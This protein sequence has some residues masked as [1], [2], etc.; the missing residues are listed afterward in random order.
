MNYKILSLCF[1]IL[2]LDVK[3]SAGVHI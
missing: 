3:N 2:V 1:S